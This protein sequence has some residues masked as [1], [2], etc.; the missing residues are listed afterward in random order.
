MDVLQV[1]APKGVRPMGP[2][3]AQAEIYKRLRAAKVRRCHRSEHQEVRTCSCGKLRA[4]H[5]RILGWKFDR[6]S[7]LQSRI[8]RVVGGS[9][10]L[11]VGA[12]IYMRGCC[13]LPPLPGET[14]T[15]LT[16]L[17]SK[18]TWLTYSPL[19]LLMGSW[20]EKY[21]A[22]ILPHPDSPVSPEIAHRFCKS[23]C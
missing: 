23:S 13:L 4:I 5:T 10:V 8:V 17:S 21:P 15:D 2:N 3:L 16:F 18:V 12:G 7:L 11:K 6:C 19:S 22:P 9:L 14:D 1:N 20:Q